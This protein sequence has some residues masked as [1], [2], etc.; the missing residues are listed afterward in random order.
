[1]LPDGW[2]LREPASE[3]ERALPATTMGDLRESIIDGEVPAVGTRFLL[4]V[5]DG[6]A[7]EVPRIAEYVGAAAEDEI[8]EGDPV[9]GPMDEAELAE[10]RSIASAPSATEIA[11][12]D[13]EA[14]VKLHHTSQAMGV[15]GANIYWLGVM[16]GAAKTEDDFRLVL[17]DGLDVL[18]GARA[19]Y[20]QLVAFT[21][22]RFGHPLEPMQQEP[23]TIDYSGFTLTTSD[24]LYHVSI[25]VRGRALELSLPRPKFPDEQT[26]T[27]YENMVA[28]AAATINDRI[29]NGGDPVEVAKEEQTAFLERARAWHES[30]TVPS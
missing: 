17:R 13:Q 20:D 5:V 3:F 9:V 15:V 28:L 29:T 27:V 12:S 4:T 10:V 7:G 8:E 23:E 21:E 6:E 22:A 24:D 26:Q 11:M 14:Y 2:I 19:L 16:F 18:N 25:D 1:M 30:I